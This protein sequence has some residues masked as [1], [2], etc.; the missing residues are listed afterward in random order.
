[1]G[2]T[3]S[4]FTGSDGNRWFYFFRFRLDFLG[5][6]KYRG[7]IGKNQLCDQLFICGQL[8]AAKGNSLAVG[9]RG[10]GSGVNL[11]CLIT[12][13][14]VACIGIKLQGSS[15][16]FQK[17]HTY[18]HIG[19]VCTDGVCDDFHSCFFYN[20]SI[21]GDHDRIAVLV[22]YPVIISI[23]FIKICLNSISCF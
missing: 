10:N 5:I 19:A 1:M 12:V 2:H 11:F 22:G 7:S 6:G 13:K 20:R 15:E 4:Y 8:F 9:C 3:G 23:V 17:V 16:S 14:A 21:T 18:P